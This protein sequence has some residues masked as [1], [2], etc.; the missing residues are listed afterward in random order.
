[1]SIHHFCAN[2]SDSELLEPIAG[3]DQCEMALHSLEKGGVSVALWRD[4]AI[5]ERGQ[6]HRFDGYMMAALH[7][8]YLNRTMREARQVD[9]ACRKLHGLEPF[10]SDTVSLSAPGQHAQ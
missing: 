4:L 6:L 8:T 5:A 10:L 7:G 1:M 3:T 9:A 2:K